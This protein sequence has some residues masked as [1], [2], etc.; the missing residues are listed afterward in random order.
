MIRQVL[1]STPFTSWA[2]LS[3]VLF[4]TVFVG[5]VIWTFHPKNHKS[6]EHAKT[7]PLGE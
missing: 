6:L 4:I 1:Q 3:L 2:I 5:V 7:I